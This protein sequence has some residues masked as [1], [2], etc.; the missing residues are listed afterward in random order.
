MVYRSCSW[1]EKRQVLDAFWRTASPSSEKINI[2]A[3]EYG[4]YAVAALVIIAVELGALVAL[5]ATREHAWSY[6]SAAGEVVTLVALW[7]SLKRSHD[8]RRR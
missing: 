7:W 6:W 5:T 3:R 1:G 4:P 2:A 8:L